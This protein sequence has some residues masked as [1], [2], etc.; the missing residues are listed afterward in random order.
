MATVT[1]KKKC[2]KDTPRCTTC[3][4]VLM[5]LEREGFAECCATGK[6]ARKRYAVAKDIPKKVA[7][8]AR[9]R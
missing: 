5:R 9:K 3:P 8:A 6:H 4:V 2:C 7:K 1:T